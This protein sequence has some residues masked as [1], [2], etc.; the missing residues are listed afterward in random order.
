MLETTVDHL[1][2]NVL[3]AGDDYFAVEDQLSR[4]FAANDTPLAWEA[5]ARLAKRRA[6]EFSIAI[7]GLTDR[8]ANELGRTKTRIR[9]DISSV[10]LWPTSNSPRLGAHDRVRGVANAYK[11]EDLTDPTLPITSIDDVLVI[12]LGYGLDGWGVG[13][14]GGIEVL[15]HETNGDKFK[16][17]GDAPVAVAAWFSFLRTNGATLPAGPHSCCGL[18]VHV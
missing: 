5:E 7:D 14:F 10:C 17:L 8:C 1:I 12:G 13:K 18:Q 4:A 15:V 9:S 2:Q 6:A 11:H 16:F 3:P